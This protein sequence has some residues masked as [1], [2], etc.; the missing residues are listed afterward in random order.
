MWRLPFAPASGLGFFLKFWPPSLIWSNF[1][2]LTSSLNSYQHQPLPLPSSFLSSPSSHCCLAHRHAFAQPVCLPKGPFSSPSLTT[3]L[4]WPSA[5][6]LIVSAHTRLSVTLT[7]TSVGSTTKLVAMYTL[8]CMFYRL[9]FSLAGSFY[10]WRKLEVYLFWVLH[11]RRC[12]AC[13][14]ENENNA[15]LLGRLESWYVR[16]WSTESRG[17]QRCSKETSWV[18]H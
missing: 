4:P 7:P 15:S 2:L 10:R 9:A 17:S 1:T 18:W 5:P 13:H 6:S 12:R 14:R 11:K 3:H 8:S 16:Y